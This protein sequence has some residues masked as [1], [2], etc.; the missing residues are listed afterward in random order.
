VKEITPEH[1]RCTI[2]ASCPSVHQR[3]DG[4]LV[5]VGRLATPADLT[6]G[7]LPP[8]DLTAEVPIVIDPAYLANV[9]RIKTEH[10]DHLAGLRRCVEEDLV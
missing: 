4:M 8:Y 7:N 2:A 3:Q 5:I 9:P 6:E 1:L 10:P